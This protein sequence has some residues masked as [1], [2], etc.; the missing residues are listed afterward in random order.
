MIGSTTVPLIENHAST[1]E[2]W[3]LSTVTDSN[4]KRAI[5]CPGFEIMM[6][7]E[8]GKQKCETCKSIWSR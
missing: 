5:E 4:E 7:A 6:K 2:R 3:S 8:T 1:R